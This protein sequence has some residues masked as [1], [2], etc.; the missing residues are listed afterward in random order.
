LSRS[1]QA[2]FELLISISIVLIVTSIMS[3]VIL[4]LNLDTILLERS[5]SA[6]TNCERI[7]NTIVNVL[8]MNNMQAKMYNYY[9]TT[10]DSSNYVAVVSY[11]EGEILCRLP[12]KNLVNST[13]YVYFSLNVGEYS[14]SNNNGT[15]RIDKL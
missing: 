10:I 9:N 5:S 4:S 14:F 12:T 1:S 13:G 15:V 2:G 8:K 7:T 6:A 3:T 11:S